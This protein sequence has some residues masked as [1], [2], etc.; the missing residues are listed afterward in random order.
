MIKLNAVR[1][2]VAQHV[3]IAGRV[4][5]IVYISV[6]V[7]FEPVNVSL[8][9]KAEDFLYRRKD[10]NLLLQL[11]ITELNMIIDNTVVADTAIINVCLVFIIWNVMPKP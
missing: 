8:L 9:W 1:A 2:A 4:F 11:V 7:H 10:N 6:T 3:R 5:R